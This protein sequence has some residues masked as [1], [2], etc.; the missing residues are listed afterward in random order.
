[1]PGLAEV[2]QKLNE[3]FNT[4][5]H[6][7]K[8]QYGSRAKVRSNSNSTSFPAPA[9]SRS[10]ARSPTKPPTTQARPKLYG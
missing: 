5:Q 1:M 8:R 9:S 7:Q 3:L 10:R 2:E 4:I 6:F